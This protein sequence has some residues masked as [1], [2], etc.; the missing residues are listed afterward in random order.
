MKLINVL[1]EIADDVNNVYPFTHYDASTKDY[2]PIE[3]YDFDTETKKYIVRFYFRYP[4]HRHPEGS[5]ERDYNTY[6][7]MSQPDPLNDKSMT[8]EHNAIKVNATV[9]AITIDWLERH[10]EDFYQLFIEPV[11]NR[12]FKLV[13]RFIDNTIAGKY[14]I[15]DNGSVI[16]I[17]KRETPLEPI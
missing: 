1:K 12:R 17:R 8:G 13:K 2:N 16:I 6:D 11:D 3:Y 15:I 14:D 9:M 7:L 4:K 10:K 5:Y